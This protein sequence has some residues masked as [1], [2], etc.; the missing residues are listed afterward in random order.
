[1]V[2]EF[3]TLHAVC[4]CFGSQRFTVALP[5]PSLN[6]TCCGIRAH[7]WALRWFIA[8]ILD[9]TMWERAMSP[10]VQLL[11]SGRDHLWSAKVQ[12]L[13]YHIIEMFSAFLLLINPYPL[14][15]CD[16]IPCRDFLCISTYI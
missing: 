15:G 6:L 4:H 16:V 13:F 1:M 14:H 7:G 2:A 11:E 10:S 9:I 3:L 8:V 12:F 5:L